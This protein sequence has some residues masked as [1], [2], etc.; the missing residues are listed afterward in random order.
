VWG[1]VT[2]LLE[3]QQENPQHWYR[4]VQQMAIRRDDRA[5]LIDVFLLRTALRSAETCRNPS[6][7]RGDDR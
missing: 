7:P 5:S 1:D 3:E 6:H 4:R 2:H